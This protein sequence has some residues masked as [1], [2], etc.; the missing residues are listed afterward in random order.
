[1]PSVLLVYPPH[2]N[3]P[4][5]GKKFLTAAPLGLCHIA[6]CVKNAGLGVDGL[7]CNTTGQ[8]PK[9]AAEHILSRGCGIVGIY[10]T[11]PALP[12]VMQLIQ[13]LRGRGVS[14]TIAV[15]GPHVTADLASSKKLGADAY[16]TGEGE[17]L[18]PGFCQEALKGWIT[19]ESTYDCGTVEDVS[20]LPHPAR[21]VFNGEY[22]YTPFATSR[23][24]PFRCAYCGMA[25]TKH[26][27]RAIDDIASE[28]RDLKAGGTKRIDLLDDS[29]TVDRQHAIDVADAVGDS[30]ISWACTTRADL[31]DAKLLT[32]MRGRGL[33]HINFGVESGNED[34]RR[35][36]RKDIPD[37][38]Y[39]NAFRNCRRLGIKTTAYGIIGGPWETKETAKQTFEFIRNL[40]PDDIMYS[41][42]ILH[43]G[44]EMH[45]IGVNDRVIEDDAWA[46][47]MCG[48][49]MPVYPPKKA[50]TEWV[51]AAIDAENRRFYFTA[52]RILSRICTSNTLGEF[53][54]NLAAG[55]VFLTKTSDK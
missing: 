4:K 16:F 25:G 23:G 20:S 27:K 43:P 29:F 48:G 19:P 12:Y 30:G 32:R 11:S 37:A 36:M 53:G 49:E 55:V 9:E 10:V 41:P 3:P 35:A 7:D 24:C 15:G 46:K 52:E 14:S 13:E 33:T 22:A 44:T 1:M 21:D 17:L 5:K 28:I 47:Y 31:V 8:N 18:F 39:V 51:R 6:S 2:E 54:E 50:D 42:L 34:A 40:E 26:R 45:R 38:D